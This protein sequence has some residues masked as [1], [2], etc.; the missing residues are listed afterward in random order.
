[1]L[2]S[3]LA[4]FA[5]TVP[6]KFLEILSG[7]LSGLVFLV[8]AD[9]EVMSCCNPLFCNSGLMLLSALL[10]LVAVF[11]GVVLSIFPEGVK[12]EG[13]G[14]CGFTNSGGSN[15]LVL[16]DN[17]GT[18]NEKSFASGGK[19]SK[20]SKLLKSKVLC[21]VV[22]KTLGNLFGAVL[23]GE[24]ILLAGDLTNKLSKSDFGLVDNDWGG[25]LTT[26]R[27]ETKIS[28]GVSV[29]LSGFGVM[30]AKAV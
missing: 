2:L 22:D 8:A 6:C 16:F 14:V 29:F 12:R 18:E 28:G 24:P 20:L 10:L 17:G 5:E 27:V 19:S 11:M 7:A 23:R 26:G 4:T 30:S 13:G 25:N 21:G 9:Y 3:I 1:L 15:C